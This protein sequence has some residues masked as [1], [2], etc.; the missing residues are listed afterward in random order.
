[1]PQTPGDQGHPREVIA[2]AGVGDLGR[3]VCEEL[4]ASPY[5]SV[6]ILTRSVRSL[7]IE[8]LSS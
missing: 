8:M 4:L 6:V 1:M 2:L 3:Y 5:F 7:K